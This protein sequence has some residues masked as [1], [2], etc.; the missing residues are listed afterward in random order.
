MGG[1]HF[2]C[3]TSSR[4]DLFLGPAPHVEY[5]PVYHPFNWRGWV[6]WGVRRDR[7]HGRAPD[8]SPVLGARISAI[9]TSIETVSTPYNKATYPTATTTYYEFPARGEHAAGEAD[10]VRRRP[11]AA[12]AR[13]AGRRA[14]STRPAACCY[15]GSKGKL[16]SRDLRR[17]PAPAAEVAARLAGSRRRS[18]RASPRATR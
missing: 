3:R 7:R 9:P 6:D 8:R 2:A 15:I 11:A 17:Q 14:S 5:H 16:M 13:G 4:W 18:C 12:E 10:V 1:G